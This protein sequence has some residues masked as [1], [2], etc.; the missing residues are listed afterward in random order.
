MLD[1]L[2][3]LN[4]GDPKTQFAGRLDLDHAAIVGHSI[5]GVAATR[6]ALD[7]ARFKGAVNFDG[8]QQSLPLWLDDQGHAQR[9][10]F[11]ELTD[12]QASVTDQN[13][14]KWKISRT[15][16]DEQRAAST[17]RVD[18]VMNQIT[19]G[20]YRV[21]TPGIRHGSF[22]DMAIWDP[23]SLEVRHRRFQIVRDY[24]RAFLDKVLRGEASTLLDSRAAEPYAE[25]KVERFGSAR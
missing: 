1:Q 15:E 10:P 24:T 16:F 22:G 21:T 7:D 25:V 5:G 18:A 17:K 14:A 8:H 2:T 9:Q 12:G 4:S 3:R 11:M 13:L 20:S 23:D 6:A 19:G